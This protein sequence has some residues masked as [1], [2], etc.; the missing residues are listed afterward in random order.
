RILPARM[1][2]AVAYSRAAGVLRMVGG[3]SLKI[4]HGTTRHDTT[5]G[6]RPA[7]NQLDAL[8]VTCAYC[9]ASLA[10][11]TLLACPVMNIAHATALPWYRAIMRNA[12]SAFAVG[13][14]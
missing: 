12:P 13:P 2:C 5:P 3:S 4:T 11:S 14:G 1:R 7:T 8:T 6:T 10:A 9:P